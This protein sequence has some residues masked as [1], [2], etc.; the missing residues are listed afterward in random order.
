M[1]VCV[2]YE[3]SLTFTCVGMLVFVRFYAINT[4]V[5]I[6]SM[7]Y[8]CFFFSFGPFVAFSTHTVNRKTCVATRFYVNF[9]D[10]CERVVVAEDRITSVIHI[11]F[12]VFDFTE[13]CRL[14]GVCNHQI[15]KYSNW[16]N[17]SFVLLTFLC[18]VTCQSTRNITRHS[19]SVLHYCTRHPSNAHLIWE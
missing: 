6:N 12:V 16:A 17:F 18:R 11:D 15:H 9:H 13:A 7:L 5:V 2:C 8:H 4:G 14:R 19:I 1:R 10:K 3:N